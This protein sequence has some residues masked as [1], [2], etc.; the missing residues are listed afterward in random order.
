MG[1]QL[2]LKQNKFM[3]NAVLFVGLL[4]MFLMLKLCIKILKLRNHSNDDEFLFQFM[5]L[6]KKNNCKIYNIFLCIFN[7]LEKKN[8]VLKK[9]YQFNN[10]N[11]FIHLL[12]II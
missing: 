7:V 9:I 10:R 8:C 6:K 3:K 5:D 2:M 4:M 12:F 11:Y 1:V